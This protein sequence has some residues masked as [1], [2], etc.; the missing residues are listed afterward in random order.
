MIC[1][2]EG[3]YI[4]RL[5][6]VDTIIGDMKLDCLDFK[7]REETPTPTSTWGRIKALVRVS[8]AG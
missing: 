4:V 5:E 6:R 8:A 7:F 1:L 2:Q 3:Y